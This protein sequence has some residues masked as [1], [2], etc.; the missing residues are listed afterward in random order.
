[1][2][3]SAFSEK[4]RVRTKRDSCGDP[5]I[6]GNARPKDMPQRVEYASHIYENG[7]GRFGLCLLFETK[8]RWTY[9]KKSLEDAGFL[10]R[11][12]GDTEGTALFDPDNWKQARLAIKLAR[13]RNRKILSPE[14]RVIIAERLKRARESKKPSQE[15]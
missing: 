7:D 10:I 5:I 12:N 11:Q 6:P 8:I 3:I 13:I 9:A 4:Y 14:Q 1:M 2:D 15:G